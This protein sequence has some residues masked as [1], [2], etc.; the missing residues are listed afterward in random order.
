MF[1][2]DELLQIGRNTELTEKGI[3]D[4]IN[5]MIKACFANMSRIVGNKSYNASIIASFKRV[6]K[7][8]IKVAEILEKE[9]KGFIKSD[10]F[11]LFID[12][13]DEFKG[14]LI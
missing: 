6:N 3:Y 12:S 5:S 13:K 8:W 11:K 4:G 7:T 14:I 10:G 2:E 1:L 9:N